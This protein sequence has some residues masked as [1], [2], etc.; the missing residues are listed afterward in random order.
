VKPWLPLHTGAPTT[1]K[2]VHATLLREPYTVQL[3]VVAMRSIMDV[4][5]ALDGVIAIAPEMERP[6]CRTVAQSKHS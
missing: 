5:N 2:L 3:C 1:A 4:H 6:A